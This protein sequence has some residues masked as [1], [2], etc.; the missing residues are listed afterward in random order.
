MADLA[1]LKNAVYA[2]YHA[3]SEGARGEANKW[4][5]EFSATPAAWEASRSL[6]AEPEQEVQ[7]FGANLLFI[8]VRSE[9]HG[10]DEGA[11]ASVYEGVRQ[12]VRHHGFSSAP[13]H[14]LS[15]SVK[16]LCL[17]LAA[18]ATRSSHNEAFVNEA[19]SIALEPGGAA[20]AI[21]L[22]AALPQESLEKL[23]M[24]HT[25]EA[26]APS[27]ASPALTS[28][29]SSSQVDSRPEFRGLMSQVRG[30]LGAAMEEKGESTS[31]GVGYPIQ[32]GRVGRA[33]R[34]GVPMRVCVCL[35]SIGVW[36]GSEGG[37]PP[38]SADLGTARFP[39]RLPSLVRY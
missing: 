28:P 7:Y 4:L 5:M 32:R 1:S 9:W 22:L 3:T 21:E 27:A 33:V 11:K 20:L 25:A 13:W 39:F 15:A 23:Q 18:A 35:Q 17:V 37:Y 38:T 19:L 30:G 16:R 26:A 14:R 36:G 29:S 6:L 31:G 8:K 34:P 10:M 2:L 24:S 12:L